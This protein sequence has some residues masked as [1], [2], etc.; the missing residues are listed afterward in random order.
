M[1][2]IIVPIDFS[3]D[4]IKGLQMACV[5]TKQLPVHIQMVYVQT[6][7][8]IDAPSQVEEEFH[9]AE[10]KF[11]QLLKDFKSLVHENSTLEY[12]IK[13]GKIYQEVVGQAHALPD[14]FIIASTH[15]ASG[16]EELFIGSNAY[17]IITA[18]NRPVI[19]LRKS[20]VPSTI[21]SIVLPV[22]V[23]SESR[24]AAAPAVFMAKVFNAKVHVVSVCS[25]NSKRI[26]SKLEA[27]TNQ[28]ISYI[29]NNEVE[30]ELT[31]LVG[32]SIPSEIV[33]FTDKINANLV[34]IVNESDSSFSELMLGSYA[35]HM[36][37]RSSVPVLT[38]R[39]RP[40]T[41]KS[42]FSTLG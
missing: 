13:K 10:R 20:I 38:I 7:F 34:S 42:S 6:K 11:K 18:T 14:S 16:F 2:N 21:N 41:I 31:N 8:G 9:Q 15:G 19:T 36:I 28:V 32:D 17:K 27:Y 23:V 40:H 12:I 29:K 24:Q 3:E 5:F 33:Q 1:K 4:S 39:A 26:K 22:D 30:Y 35:Q 37:S 25:S